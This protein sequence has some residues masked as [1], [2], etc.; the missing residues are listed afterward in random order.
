MVTGKLV[1][2]D[3]SYTIEDEVLDDYELLEILGDIDAGQA[4]KSQ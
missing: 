4:Q 3:F 2:Y 1:D